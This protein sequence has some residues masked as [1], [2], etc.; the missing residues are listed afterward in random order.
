MVKQ[1]SWD[2]WTLTIFVF[3]GHANHI[4]PSYQVNYC[5]KTF[6]VNKILYILTDLRCLSEAEG[7]V[8]V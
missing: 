5:I 7:H 1:N 3:E 2:F 8:S 4:L 6:A